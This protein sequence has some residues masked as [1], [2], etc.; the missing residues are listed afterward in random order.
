MVVKALVAFVVAPLLAFPLTK[1]A[2]RPL[3]PLLTPRRAKSSRDLIGQSCVIRTGSADER[4]GEAV[5][6]DTGP[7]LVL[8]VRVEG[9]AM[10]RGEEGV[11]VGFD[12]ERE[13]YIVEP[14]GSRIA[15]GNETAGR[16]RLWFPPRRGHATI[17]H[18][19][20]ALAPHGS[21]VEMERSLSSLPHR[22][23]GSSSCSGSARC[24]RASTVR[25][26]K[27]RR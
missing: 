20:Y 9:T 4:F 3:A 27:A 25:S 16:K 18:N 17:G 15:H 7:D 13:E 22:S 19:A 11:I 26:S 10:K 6:K 8:R 12:E 1:L 2:T 5:V 23:R 24:S 21:E 14:D